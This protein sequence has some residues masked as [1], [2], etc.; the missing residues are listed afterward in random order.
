[1]NNWQKKY[2]T[3]FIMGMAGYSILLPISLIV[4]GDGR[5]QQP[6]VAILITL[7]PIAPFLNAMTAVVQNVRHQDEMQQRI[8]LESILVTA[9]LTGAVTFSYGLLEATELVPPLPTVFIAPFMIAVWGIS[10][11][12]ITR[13]YD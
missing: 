7:L 1:M 9:L 3:R 5:V 13:R 6:W 10:N 4:V 11:L 2:L 8:H 12:L